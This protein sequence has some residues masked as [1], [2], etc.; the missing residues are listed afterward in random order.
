MVATRPS[1]DPALTDRSTLLIGG[2]WVP[3]SGDVLLD[4]VCPSTEEVFARVP[5]ATPAEIDRALESARR[6]F[7]EGPWPHMSVH[8]RADILERIAEGIEARLDEFVI[9]E[10]TETGLP[11]AQ[12]RGRAAHASWVFRFYAQLARDYAFREDRART[13]GSPS[14]VLREPVG[15]VA[16]ITPWNGP[17]STLALKLAPALAAGCTAVVKPA[18]ETPLSAYLIGNIMVEAG[19]PAGVVNMLAGGREIGAYLVAHPG[20]DKV[21]FTGSSVAGKRI[22]ASCAD[23]LSRVTLELGGKSAAIVCDDADIETFVPTIVTGGTRSNGQAC[24][25]QTRVLVTPRRRDELVDR[26]VRAMS[27]IKVGSAYD[28]ETQLGP[29]AMQRQRDRVE[30]YIAF[31]REE[32]AKVVHGGGRPAGLDRGYFVEPTLFVDVDNSM[33]I[34]QEE[35]FGPVVSVIEVPDVDAA[36]ATANDTAY[37]LSGTVY[38]ADPERGFEIARRIR[39]GTLT[40]N[41]SI[42]DFAVPFGGYK[43]SGI[44]REGGPEGLEAFLETKTIHMPA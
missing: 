28:P 12:G 13:D 25:A 43:E 9:L 17:T 1:L 29:L 16:A 10:A 7:D 42:I 37:G 30:G 11:I 32:G 20:V 19:L 40:V 33:R 24:W 3:G 6:A 41:G 15:V 36:V 2:E 22:M 44:G 39:T 31:G 14:R 8:E 18:P 35:I 27:A 34:A 38:T 5:E 21:A 4:L 26:M 23:R